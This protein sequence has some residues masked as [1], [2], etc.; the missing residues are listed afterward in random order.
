MRRFTLLQIILTTSAHY[1][2][3]KKF[4]ACSLSSVFGMWIEIFRDPIYRVRCD[5]CELAQARPSPPPCQPYRANLLRSHPPHF[6]LTAS[7]PPHHHLSQ[8]KCGGLPPPLPCVF[9][10]WGS[11]PVWVKDAAKNKL[12]A[13]SLIGHTGSSNYRST[14]SSAK[15]GAT[16]PGI[17]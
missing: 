8:S 6:A 4:L 13:A 16:I 17:S 9:G 3:T 12:K 5:S 7:R 10:L 11:R 1:N 14:G 15:R 2:K